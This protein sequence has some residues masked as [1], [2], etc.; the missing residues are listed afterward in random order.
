MQSSHRREQHAREEQAAA[1]LAALIALPSYTCNNIGAM[2]PLHDAAVAFGRKGLESLCRLRSNN[3][4]HLRS[5][6]SRVIVA[7]NNIHVAKLNPNLTRA[8]APLTHLPIITNHT[9]CY[10]S[11][12]INF[13]TNQTESISNDQTITANKGGDKGIFA[14]IWDRYSFQ[15]Q[16]KRIILGERLFRSVQYRANDP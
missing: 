16:Q 9:R 4:T 8:S 1:D 3:N 2:T 5:I 12:T 7:N 15:G 14:K 13:G 10:S 11:S 6:S